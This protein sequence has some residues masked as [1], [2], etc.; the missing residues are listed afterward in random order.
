MISSASSPDRASRP[1]SVSAPAE[2]VTRAPAPRPD[3]L[4]IGQAAFLRSELA[5]Q[6]EIRPEVV[7]RGLK[8]A[9]DPAYPDPSILRAIAQQILRA[10][11]PSEQES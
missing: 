6:P 1:E 2:S 9:A 3:S 4:S 11:D 5:R 10:D 7:A 8:L